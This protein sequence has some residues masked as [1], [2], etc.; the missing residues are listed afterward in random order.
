MSFIVLK[1]GNKNYR[2][3]NGDSDDKLSSIIE[4]LKKAVR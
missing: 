4:K 1:S 3:R 2:E